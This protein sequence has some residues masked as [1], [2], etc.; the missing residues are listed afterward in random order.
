MPKTVDQLQKA[1]DKVGKT[2]P[3][4]NRLTVERSEG[5]LYSKKWLVKRD[6]EVYAAFDYSAGVL[7]WAG[8]CQATGRFQVPTKSQCSLRSMGASGKDRKIERAEQ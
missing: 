8:Y 3:I 5:K 4:F 2:V 6:G 7:A 1:I